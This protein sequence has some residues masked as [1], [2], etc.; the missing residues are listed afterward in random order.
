MKNTQPKL[1]KE[2]KILN[3]LQKLELSEWWKILCEAL[4]EDKQKFIHSLIYEYRGIDTK[5][6]YSKADLI[7]NHIELI[8]DMITMPWKIK[9][10]TKPMIDIVAPTNM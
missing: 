7:R 10:E 6:E 8:E 1:T 4:N 9:N 3:D 2:Q 5:L